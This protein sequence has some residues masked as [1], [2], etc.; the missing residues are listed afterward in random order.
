MSLTDVESRQALAASE[1][2]RRGLDA[3]LVSSAADVRY[4]TGFT[5]SNGWLLLSSSGSVLLTDG[6]Y[7]EQASRE[8]EGAEVRIV[9]G[10]LVDGLAAAAEPFA[11]VGVPASDVSHAQWLELEKRVQVDWATADGIVRALRET[12]S[13][14]EIAS[15]E[16]AVRLTE[17]ALAD[18]LIGCRVGMT[19]QE[20]AARIEFECRS[21]GATRMAFDTIVATGP[22]AALP[23]A[24]PSD[25]AVAPGD[26]LIVDLGC[27]VDGYCSDMTR[28]V[29]AGEPTPRMESVRV[30][31]GRALDAAI[32]AIGPGCAAK[33]VD[34]TAR[35]VLAATG[36][37]G[38]FSHSLGHGVGLEVHE[39]PRL[40]S[41][42]SDVLE[43]GA[44]ITVEPGV[45]LPGEG[46]IRIE[47]MVV[48]TETGCRRLNRLP[49]EPL[50]LAAG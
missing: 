49:T 31:V 6:R 35:R 39:A 26:T 33:D 29:V 18:A 1:S 21:R 22:N 20:I 36:L 43:P 11:R 24:R 44:V 14:Q 48:V 2:E 45:Y 9:E 13:A 41:R 25:T 40:S 23:H 46:G 34:E 38:Y 32:A 12:K 47:D 16:A 30:E 3:L 50:V 27:V 17:A 19:E 8:V 37:D 4:L 5:G 42:S 15:I 7:R 28:V 10:S